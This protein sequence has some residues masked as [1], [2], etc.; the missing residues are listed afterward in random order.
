MQLAA[1]SLSS[2]PGYAVWLCTLLK[3]IHVRTYQDALA[4]CDNLRPSSSVEARFS[5]QHAVAVS[6]LNGAPQL[7]Y[8]KTDALVDAHIHA[9][10][11][12]VQVSEDATYTHRYPQHFGASIHITLIDGTKLDAEIADAWGDPERP[13][14]ANQVQDK[15]RL[16]MKTAGWSQ[17][18]IE[19]KLD[20]CI[21]LFNNP[22]KPT[23]LAPIKTLPTL[24]C[25]V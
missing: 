19:C 13:M 6:L 22:Q 5:L 11:E 20:A 14:S 24:N 16:L 10:R 18:D 15:A 1:P 23:T 7:D 4:F 25:R 9:I 8:F 21:A 17:A 2:T 12:K 3:S